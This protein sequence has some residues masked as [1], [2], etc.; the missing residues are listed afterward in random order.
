MWRRIKMIFRSMFGWLIRGAE[1]PE[2][3]LRQHMEDLRDRLPELNRQVAEVVKLEKMLEMQHDRLEKKVEDLDRQ[4]TAAVKMGESHKEAAKTLIAALQTARQDLQETEAQLEQAKKN[5]EQ[6]M[7][8]RDAY[9]R[10]IKRDIQ[11]TMSQISRA[12]RAE[13]QEEMS[14]LLTSFEIGD[15]SDVLDRMTERID[16]KMARGEARTEVAQ[17]TVDVRMMDIEAAAVE[18]EAEQMYREYQRQLGL[19]ED[20]EPSERTMEPL[21]TESEQ[22][23]PPETEITTEEG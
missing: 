13:I 3:I 6:T 18:T 23:E 22:Q 11:E 16:E 20:E 12:K 9:E 19:V 2:M 10:K 7:K 8:M 15:E 21:E 1:N 5:S 14:S 4:V 17:S